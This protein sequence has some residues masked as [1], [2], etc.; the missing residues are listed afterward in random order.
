[1]KYVNYHFN[2]FKNFTNYFNGHVARMTQRL[3]LLDTRK[4]T[5]LPCERAAQAQGDVDIPKK[6]TRS[7]MLS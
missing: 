2:K 3:C 7:G 6:K 4:L 5:S 1:M